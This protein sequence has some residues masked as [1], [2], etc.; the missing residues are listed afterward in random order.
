[1]KKIIW[2]AF[3]VSAAACSQKNTGRSF[4]VEGNV[5]NTDAKMIYLEEDVA[6]GQPVIMDS[7]ELKSG[8]SF[9]LQSPVKEEA[10]YQLRLKG[11]TVPL[12]F[13]VNDVPKVSVQA[14][15]ANAAQPYTITGSPASQAV[16]SYDKE[17]KA[18]AE[19][20][21]AEGSA[22]DSL[23]AAK[24][25]DSVIALTYRRVEQNVADAKAYATAFLKNT[26]SP[27]L[28]IYAISAFQNILNNIGLQG[29]SPAEI[30][31]AVS[32]ASAKFPTHSGIQA[33]KKSLAPSAAPDF[34]QPDADGKPVSLSS[35]KGKYVLLDFWASWCGPCRHENP[36]VV[37]AYNEFKDKNFTVFSVSLDQNKAAWQKAIQQDGLTWTHASDLKFWN[38]EAAVL[39]G[40]Q[41]IPAN[42]LI[43]PQGNIIAKDLREGEL[44]ETLRRTIK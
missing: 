17:L 30:T 27:V 16:V 15:L 37:K 22:V 33:I 23:K 40:V 4:D 29:F 7:A 41:S 11:K 20:I 31:D 44:A 18:K 26:N 10:F 35:F 6:A 28:L 42:F 14:D 3:A 36:N 32:T 25:P 9:R 2:M 12:A 8:G 19:K 24:A 34:T 39:Y 21:V 13:L 38:N 5:K 1:M 43:D